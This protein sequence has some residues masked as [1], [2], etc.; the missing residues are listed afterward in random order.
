VIVSTP[1]I[2]SRSAI[3]V[4]GMSVNAE[5]GDVTEPC[6]TIDG[7]SGAGHTSVQLTTVRYGKRGL[8]LTEEHPVTDRKAQ[9]T[10]IVATSEAKPGSP[11]SRCSFIGRVP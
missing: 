8:P 11:V 5:G 4:K 1:A 6:C 9:I 7:G 3:L 2:R 10:S